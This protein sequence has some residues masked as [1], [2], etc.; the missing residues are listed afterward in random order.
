MQTQT[1]PIKR[2]DY[3]GADLEEIPPT[4]TSRYYHLDPKVRFLWMLSRGITW[5]IFFACVFFVLIAGLLSGAT[6]AGWLMYA[7]LGLFLLSLLHVA[8]PMIAYRHWSIALRAQDMLVRSGVIWKHVVAIPFSRIQHVDSHSGPL[9][10]SMGLA[11]LIVHTAG[12][13]LGAIAVP[14]LPIKRAEVLRDYL[15]KVGHTDANL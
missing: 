14:G 5:T 9:E 13:H 3:L 1:P 11:N 15:S 10:R 7:M 6:W 2:I 8:W 4:P 12:A